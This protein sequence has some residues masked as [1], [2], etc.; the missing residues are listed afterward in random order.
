MS[1]K[2]EKKKFSDEEKIEINK[3][4]EDCKIESGFTW[5]MT[6][7]SLMLVTYIF[8]NNIFVIL[9]MLFFI[10]GLAK[11]YISNLASNYIYYSCYLGNVCNWVNI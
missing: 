5:Y 6:G 11:T 1:G 4:K 7:I 10:F 2:I 8:K 3:I 9:G